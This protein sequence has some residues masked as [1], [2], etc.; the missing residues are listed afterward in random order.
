MGKIHILLVADP[1]WLRQALALIINREPDFTV[2]AQVGALPEARDAWDEVDVALVHLGLPAVQRVEAVRE[3]HQAHAGVRILAL[4]A[5]PDPA[6]T[7]RALEAGATGVLQTTASLAEIIGGIRRLAAGEWL[8]SPEEIVQLL[9]RATH[10]REQSREA[11]L[12]LQQ[13]TVREREVL[14]ALATGLDSK[15]IA[16]LLG[17]TISTERVHMMNILSKLGVHTRTQALVFAVRHGAVKI[18]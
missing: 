11:Q 1:G 6:Q 4:A 8:Q 2:V 3:L 15:E 5:G 10:Q 14:Q 16:R 12:A 18:Y 7:A 9:G 13:L 17:I